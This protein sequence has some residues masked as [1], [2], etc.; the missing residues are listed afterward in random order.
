M[1]QPRLVTMYM[2]QLTI[3]RE[4][5]EDIP[6]LLETIIEQRIKRGRDILTKLNYPPTEVNLQE[7]ADRLYECEQRRQE[8]LKIT[9]TRSDPTREKRIIKRESEK[10]RSPTRPHETIMSFD[11]LSPEDEEKENKKESNP[12]LDKKPKSPNT[13]W[14]S[15]RAEMTKG[16]IIHLNNPRTR[17][18]KESAAKLRLRQKGRGL[19]KLK[20]MRKTL[21]KDGGMLDS[22]NKHKIRRSEDNTI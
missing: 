18:D 15:A 13:S 2:D 8:N 1:P 12:E 11:D 14:S 20:V 5:I 4:I 7:E 6:G 19:K 10:P 16:K 21:R 22:R 3:L 9:L 17:E